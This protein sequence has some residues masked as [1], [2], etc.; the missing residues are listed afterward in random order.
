MKATIGL[1]APNKRISDNAYRAL[2]DEILNKRLIVSLLNEDNI[3]QQAEYLIKKGADLIIARGGTYYDLIDSKLPVPVVQLNYNTEDILNSINHARKLG[4]KVILILTSNIVFEIERWKDILNAD[5]E[6]IKFEHRHEIDEVIFNIFE[7]YKEP[8]ILGGTFTCSRADKLGMK[9]VEIDN[10]E[11]TIAA[12]YLRAQE[13]M[14][15]IFRD[16][17][18]LQLLSTVLDNVNEGILFINQEG[19]V[20]HYNNNIL[21]FFPDVTKQFIDKKLSE[22]IPELKFVIESLNGKKIENHI[23]KKGKFIL[24]VNTVTVNIE[25]NKL[26][27]VCTMQDLTEIQKLEEDLRYK[28][29]PKGLSSKYTFEN[30]FTKN[31][32]MKEVIEN[33]K[34]FARA[35]ST[36][37]IYG[38]SGTGK[39]MF[40]QS[41]HNYSERKNAPF[42][43]VNCGALS[44]S[45][46]ESE[47]FG[48]VEGAFTGARKGGKQGLFELAHKG[49]IFLDEINSLPLEIQSKFLRII[50]EKEVMRLG[51]DYVIPLDVRIIVASN[52]K[53]INMVEKGEFRRD[54]FYRLNVLEIKIPT[55]KER[56]DDII[57]LFEIFLKEFNSYELPISEELAVKLKEYQWKGNIREL[58]N[59][60]ERYALLKDKMNFEFLNESNDEIDFLTDDL[61][62]DLKELNKTVEELVI[63]SLI[64]K[65]ISKNEISNILG[66]SRTA[67]WK[68]INNN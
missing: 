36:I 59:V 33:T 40:A 47:L 25:G 17:K 22:V 19:I 45:L 34:E 64:N 12:T 60:A 51:S 31:K 5:L 67:L 15:L 23:L 65:G 29:N 4:D 9:Y 68:K 50:E 30:I 2:K 43:A 7:K 32:K 11:A 14:D 66:I 35:D 53:L 26:G 24:N 28:L 62:I 52:E 42:V 63:E 16:N 48:Y 8:V 49:T 1:I 27:I 20:E 54:L 13:I 10:S 44:E 39:E 38:E 41:I 37:L 3:V 61:K 21:K 6:L 58:R 18:H 55:L 57:P 56:Q 46:L